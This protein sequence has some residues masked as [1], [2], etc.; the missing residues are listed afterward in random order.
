MSG[1]SL[2]RTP[3]I[4]CTTRGK[5]LWT[6][7]QSPGAH[8]SDLRF[9]RPPAV[10]EKNFPGRGEMATNGADKITHNRAR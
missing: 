2:W 7:T 1:P 10:E 3:R 8:P 5:P 6:N 4:L 9:Y